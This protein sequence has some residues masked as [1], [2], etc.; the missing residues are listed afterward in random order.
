MKKCSAHQG[1]GRPPIDCEA[2]QEAQMYQ[3]PKIDDNATFNVGDKIIKPLFNL[4][5]SWESQIKY[6]KIG[7]IK[8]INNNVANVYYPSFGDI[9]EVDLSLCVKVV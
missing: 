4:Y 5:K 3:M 8:S 7:E 2:C 6:A 9:F 1:R